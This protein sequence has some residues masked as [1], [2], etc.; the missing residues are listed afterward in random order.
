M[1]NSIH[2]ITRWKPVSS[3]DRASM[4][5]DG[6]STEVTPYPAAISSTAPR[7]AGLSVRSD[8][9]CGDVDRGRHLA[10][11]GRPVDHRV[12][13][14]ERA[15]PVDAVDL[16]LLHPP[17]GE[18]HRHQVTDRDTQGLRGGRFQCDALR[19]DRG[20]RAVDPPRIEHRVDRHPRR[21]R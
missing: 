3:S 6:S 20:G 7:S 16:E 1:K 19:I 15:G 9:Q 14:Q 4:N 12:A 5:S 21:R 13:E 2:W 18:G 17:A 11:E 10:L 8:D